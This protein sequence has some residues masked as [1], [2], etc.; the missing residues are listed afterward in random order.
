MQEKVLINLVP[1]GHPLKPHSAQAAKQGVYCDR[2]VSHHLIPPTLL[3]TG[4]TSTGQS[5]NVCS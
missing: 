3:L 5:S 1:D 2:S 4:L